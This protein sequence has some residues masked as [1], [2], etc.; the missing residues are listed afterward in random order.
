MMILCLPHAGG[1]AAAF[2]GWQE[3]LGGVAQVVA[4]EPAGAGARRSEAPATSMAELVAAQREHAIA[5]ARSASRYAL[6]GH[7]LGAL[8][9]RE[10]AD[11]L[12]AAGLPPALLVACGRNGPCLPPASDPIADL[13]EPE[14]LDAV[15][16]FGGV[17]AA[18]RA[19]P[20]LL[21][22][23]AATLRRDIAIAETWRRAPGGPRLDCRI[24]VL[25]GAEDPLVTPAGAATWAAETTGG[26][27]TSTH[28]GDHFFL[29]EPGFART[30]VRPLLAPL[31]APPRVRQV[32]ALERT[33]QSSPGSAPAATPGSSR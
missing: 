30:V 24:Q 14:L 27:T 2:R 9:A 19:E 17:P 28:A 22:R 26:C 25:A 5:A 18:V 8:V 23:F 11:E 13:P 33:T 12:V 7:S 21:A 16:G 29:H 15:V 31:A 32:T 20:D 6:L 1:T 3:Q 4:L 10:L